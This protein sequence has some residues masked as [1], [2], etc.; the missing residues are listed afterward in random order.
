MKGTIIVGGLSGTTSRVAA[1]K[2]SSLSCTALRSPK[3]SN[4][5]G[6]AMDKAGNCYADASDTS[7]KVGL[8]YYARCAKAGVELGS[9][10]GFNEP[11]YGGL[12]VDNEGNIVVISTGF[13]SAV[14][15]YSGCAK[16]RC[17]VISG[18]FV[19]NGESIFGH[20]GRDNQRWVT[21][22]ID[23]G[24]VDVYAY[25]GHGT[26]LTYLY[27]FDVPGCTPS[28]F[29]ESAAYSPGSPKV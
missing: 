15:V 29:C 8:W 18:P 12:S 20:L 23:G 27:S 1:C 4:L 10:Q 3:M 25:V 13:P 22:N 19:L 9:A 6:V 17:S 14:T 21:V 2:L 5:A 11:N 28:G 24:T 7:G 16:A 26:G